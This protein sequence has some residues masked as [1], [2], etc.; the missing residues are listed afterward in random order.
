MSSTPYPLAPLDVPLRPS[1]VVLAVLTVLCTSTTATKDGVEGRPVRHRHYPPHPL[2][3]TTTAANAT[4]TAVATPLGDRL[5][6]L[7]K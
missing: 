3:T 2:T 6:L 1:L 4:T 5:W 7:D